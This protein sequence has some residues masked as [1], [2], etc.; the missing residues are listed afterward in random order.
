MLTVG[1][2]DLAIGTA[3]T[4]TN[5]LLVAATDTTKPTHV[6]LAKGASG[7]TI[8]CGRIESNQVY[9]TPVVDGDPTSLK[10]G[11]KVTISSDGTGVTATTSDGVATIVDL[12]G[13]EASGDFI[14]VRF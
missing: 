9:E 10:V 7:K 3:C 11:Q 13:A 1:A 14:Q 2:S 6:T 8:P 5:G 12:L 4:V